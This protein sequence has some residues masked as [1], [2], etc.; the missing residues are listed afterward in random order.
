MTN[1]KWKFSGRSFTKFPGT[2]QLLEVS[3]S[4]TW[5]DVTL[6]HGIIGSLVLPGTNRYYRQGNLRAI[7]GIS[8]DP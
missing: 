2:F 3:R 4:V 6:C 7:S 1:D 8:R 5:G